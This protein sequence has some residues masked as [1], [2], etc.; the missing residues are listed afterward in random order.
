MMWQE[1]PPRADTAMRAGMMG[2]KRPNI[3]LLK[4]TAMASELSMAAGESTAK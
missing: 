4:V 1:R 2:A 3:W